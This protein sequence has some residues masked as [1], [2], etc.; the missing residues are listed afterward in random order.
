MSTAQLISVSA[1]DR[2]C[3]ATDV[4]PTVHEP[5][6]ESKFGANMK[7]LKIARNVP[8]NSSILLLCSIISYGRKPTSPTLGPCGMQFVHMRNSW[9]CRYQL[10][11]MF[12]LLCSTGPR[13][14]ATIRADHQ[15][16]ETMKAEAAR[17]R[18]TFFS[19]VLF[20]ALIG[21]AF[22]AL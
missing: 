5:G 4:R 18:R 19:S 20:E 13:D 7:F 2:W 16:S 3:H 6:P 15:R 1:D 21:I 10:Q 12:S 14:C 11:V 17:D 8:H 22:D 9:S